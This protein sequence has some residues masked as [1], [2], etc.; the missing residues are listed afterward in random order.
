MATVS[1]IWPSK[2][3]K[4]REDQTVALKMSS[5][6]T[7]DEK[8]LIHVIHEY[9]EQTGRIECVVALEKDLNDDLK[10]RV[11]ADLA[12]LRSLCLNG[13]WEDVVECV[14]VFERCEQS[15]GCLCAVHKQWYLETLSTKQSGVQ[16][17]EQARVELLSD[18]LAKLKELCS[19]EQDYSALCS[20]LDQPSLRA[21]PDY[22]T[23]SLYPAR[24]KVFHT[25]GRW[26]SKF[27]YP[28]LDPLTIFKEEQTDPLSA[29][30]VQLV[31]KGLM[32]EKCEAIALSRCQGE[33][34]G[35]GSTMFDLSG[36]MQQQPD[37]AF[38][39][40]PSSCQ[41]TFNP[42]NLVSAPD[43][44]QPVEKMVT[45]HGA[46]VK[47]NETLNSIQ[48]GPHSSASNTQHTPQPATSGSREEEKGSHDPSS[49]PIDAVTSRHTD[50]VPA[51]S[52]DNIV[53]TEVDAGSVDTVPEPS[54]ATDQRTAVKDVVS[55]SKP[56]KT[57]LAESVTRS[58]SSHTPTAEPASE[59]VPTPHKSSSIRVRESHSSQSKIRVLEEFEDNFIS[60]TPPSAR[61]LPQHK[62]GRDSST[63]KPSS[64][65]LHLQPSP[66]TSP[67]GRATSPVGG[68][69]PQLQ[70]GDGADGRGPP[71]VEPR[72]HFDFSECTEEVSIE[73]P[74][75]T[76]LSQ[77]KD[78]QV[79]G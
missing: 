47:Q 34:R 37:S 43:P 7:I 42:Q 26:M 55:S 16:G 20:L 46:R 77:V 78:A 11:P 40:P 48:T 44:S 52:K 1:K 23:W 27:I 65:K 68:D 38:Q 75:V 30:L 22:S 24:L 8:Q 70:R 50:S 41:L 74:T 71:P 39:I 62:T 5:T 51:S 21:S 14:K 72:R 60:S 67:V 25:I 10:P 59:R 12:F 63:P 64:N 2:M 49:P 32:Y 31:A 35:E 15:Q 66:P 79:R 4:D 19:L 6:V 73:W 61:L 53:V 17:S 18:L 57:K 13:R 33:K 69:T 9:L 3:P 45:E 29:K 56:S 76:M 58:G 54:A 28:D 36:W